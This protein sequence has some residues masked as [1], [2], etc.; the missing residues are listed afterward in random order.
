MFAIAWVLFGLVIIALTMAMITTALTSISLKSDTKLYGSKVSRGF[1][2]LNKIFTVDQTLETR[3]SSGSCARLRIKRPGFEPC[4]GHCVVFLARHFTLTVPLST[5]EYK[6]VP[7]NCQ[8]NLTKCWRV[9][10][11]GLASH[12]GGVAIFLVATCYKSGDK[13]RQLCVPG[14]WLNLF[15][16]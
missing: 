8:G 2:I 10:F 12:P 3:W 4:P 7:A 1:S 13:L 16:L 14:S 9:T 11:D 5:Q 15:F 6:W